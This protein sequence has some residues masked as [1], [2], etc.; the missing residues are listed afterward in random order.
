MDKFWR[1]EKENP[2]RKI[3]FGLMV[4]LVLWINL[5]VFYQFTLIAPGG[6]DSIPRWIGTKAW[7]YEGIDP[8]SAEVTSRSQKMIYGRLATAGEDQQKFVYPFYTILYYLPFVWMKFEWA[9]AVYMLILEL[10]IIAMIVVSIKALDWSPPRWLMIS[11]ILFGILCYHSIRTIVLWQLAGICAFFITLALWGIKNKQ[12][13][14]AGISLALASIKPQMV[15]L[16]I[17]FLFGCGLILK[18][19]KISI[20]MLVTLLVLVGGSFLLLPAWLSEMIRQI[21][22]YAHYTDT[23]SPLHII[24]HTIFPLLGDKAEW[25]LILILIVWLIY[26]WLQV[27]SFESEHFIWVFMLTLIITNLI[28]LRTA[29]TNYLMMFPVLILLFQKLSISHIQKVNLWIWMIELVYLIGTWVLFIVT[30]QGREEQWQ[31][32]LPFP[33]FLLIGM[34]IIRLKNW[35]PHSQYE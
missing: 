25:A 12:D 4:F 32:Y 17:P 23:V 14:I 31:M 33:L 7:L 26:E 28:A 9:R 20:T 21:E 30:V 11:T 2:S 27:S 5:L 13:I 6:N 15:F 16:I 29:T 34:I 35:F 18:R 22:D 10:A 3:I 8:Y 24:T 19:W 1:F